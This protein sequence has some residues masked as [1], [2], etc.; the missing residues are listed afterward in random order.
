MGGLSSNTHKLIINHLASSYFSCYP[1]KPPVF[2]S[3]YKTPNFTPIFSTLEVFSLCSVRLRAFLTTNW[4]LW[5]L[6]NILACAR[7]LCGLYHPSFPFHFILFNFFVLLFGENV[8]ALSR[9]VL[10]NSKDVIFL[11]ELLS[12]TRLD[13]LFRWWKMRH[14]CLRQRCSNH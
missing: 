14:C 2:N 3:S 1:L 11:Q 5:F 10:G 7:I 12:N 6:V 9:N 4:I 13:L 8:L